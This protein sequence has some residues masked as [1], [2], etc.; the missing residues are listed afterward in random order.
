MEASFPEERRQTLAAF[1]TY[2]DN[3]SAKIAHDVAT[4]E[5]IYT[6][7]SSP[8]S[9]MEI[10]YEKKYQ[11]P[12]MLGMW[13][14]KLS[15]FGFLISEPGSDLFQTPSRFPELPSPRPEEPFAND[16]AI[17]ERM[18]KLL[19]A[20]FPAK[21]RNETVGVSFNEKPHIWDSLTS[22][23]SAETLRELIIAQ[24]RILEKIAK[25]AAFK[26]KI[27]I[28]DLGGF[29]GN[30]TV[31]LNRLL[32]DNVEYMTVVHSTKFVQAAEATLDAFGVTNAEVIKAPPVAPLTAKI[33]KQFDGIFLFHHE[34]Y[35]SRRDRISD[36]VQLL[37]PS[38]SLAGFLPLREKTDQPLFLEWLW[39]VIPYFEKYPTYEAFRATLANCGFSSINLQP[40]PLWTFSAI[41]S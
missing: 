28:L 19:A 32:P 3:L 10:A 41:R 6:L 35:S 14:N 11:N 16:L 37:R 33:K 30:T 26:E 24:S 36:L 31:T 21:L 34:T 27:H 40:Q 18:T 12:E 4:Q 1:V 17:W 8:K 23:E 39:S 15:A 20:V 38:G 7:L 2:L 22:L 5:G 29:T 13:L 9:L 25:K